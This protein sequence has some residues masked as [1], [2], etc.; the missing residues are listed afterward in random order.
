MAFSI[1]TSASE[2]DIQRD[3]GQRVLPSS[4][5]LWEWSLSKKTFG[6]FNKYLPGSTQ[7]QLSQVG[8]ANVTT[9]TSLFVKLLESSMPSSPK[10]SISTQVIP[11]KFPKASLWPGP[12]L[13]LSA[14]TQTQLQHQPTHLSPLDVPG[15]CCHCA[16]SC[17]PPAHSPV[18]T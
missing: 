15:L 12:L 6:H 11:P 9:K 8:H 7:Y 3:A 4:K 10:E 2:T 14:I 17:R 18:A 13:P 16:S 1:S 5:H